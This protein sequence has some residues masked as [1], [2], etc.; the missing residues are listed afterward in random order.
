MITVI[1]PAHNEAAVI[2][3]GLEAL[4]RGARPGELDVIVACNGCSDGTAEIARRF[5]PSVRVIEI[6]TAS[7]IAALNAADE[8]ARGFPR[9]YVDADV[10][11]GIADLRAI[12]ASLQGGALAAWPTPEMD[13]S[14]ASWAVRAFYRVWMMLPYNRAGGAVGAGVYA[15]SEQ[16]RARFGR[17]PDVIA[18]DGFV[19]FQFAPHER[20]TVEAAVSR[21]KPPRT[22]AGLLRIKTRSRVGQYQLAQRYPQQ[23]FSDARGGGAL[24]A[25]L[26]RPDLWP[27]ACVYLW[28]NWCSRR[29]ARAKLAAMSSFVW[30]R[31][32]SRAIATE[33]S[34]R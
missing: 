10:E 21:V 12:A 22:L 25:L 8:A 16:G 15:L 6:E 11:L 31:D 33:G 23:R 34:A 18:D 29:R 28:V 13:F 27:A 24:K 14:E 3:R 20:V 30:E 9:V 1:V 32:D 5:G 19:R 7:K 2:A 17:F 4:L 26:K